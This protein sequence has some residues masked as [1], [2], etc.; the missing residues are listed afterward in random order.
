MS[1]IT[2]NNDTNGISHKFI[3]T[4]LLMNKANSVSI[5]QVSSGNCN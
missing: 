4:L 5:N 3:V 2:Y 1:L